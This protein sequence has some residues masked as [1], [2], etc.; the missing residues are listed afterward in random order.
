MHTFIGADRH[1]MRD[2]AKILAS[3]RKRLFDERW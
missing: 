3:C 1:W 2:T